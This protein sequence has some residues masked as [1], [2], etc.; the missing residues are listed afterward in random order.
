MTR[1]QIAKKWAE[2]LMFRS[3]GTPSLAFVE[4][5]ILSAIKEATKELQ[6][7][8]DR[9][10]AELATS[11]NGKRRIKYTLRKKQENA[12]RIT[13]QIRK[14]K[15]ENAKLLLRINET[16]PEPLVGSMREGNLK[17]ALVWFAVQ[18]ADKLSAKEHLGW[19]GWND[20]DFIEDG[21]CMKK[22]KGHVEKLAAG[23]TAQAVDVANFCMFIA[24]YYHSTDAAGEESKDD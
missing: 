10:K 23:D 22:L 24:Y 14:Y 5:A 4:E 7:E 8:K 17:R 21:C 6:G 13:E 1:E 19:Q 20:V 15:A 9:L 18:M 3:N 11:R 2:L 12:Q 16:V